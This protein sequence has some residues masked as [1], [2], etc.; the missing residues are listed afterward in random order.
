MANDDEVQPPPI[1]LAGY[2]ARQQARAIILLTVLVLGV[3]AFLFIASPGGP[4]PMATEDTHVDALAILVPL[5]GIAML[6]FGLLWMVRIYRS[7]VDVEPDHG[8][9]RYRSR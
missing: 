5:V 7:A 3:A 4:S 9:W 2:E 6:L 1:L 8:N